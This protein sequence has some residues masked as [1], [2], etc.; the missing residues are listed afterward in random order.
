V[1]L[2]YKVNL[3]KSHFKCE[4]ENI[5]EPK[6][7]KVGVMPGLTHSVDLGMRRRMDPAVKG[8]M[9][10]QKARFLTKDV[11]KQ[12][13]KQ[14]V[15]QA[16]MA[17]QNSQKQPLLAGVDESTIDALHVKQITDETNKQEEK[18]KVGKINKVCTK[19]AKKMQTTKKCV[20][21]K[22][23]EN[24]CQVFLFSYNCDQCEFGSMCKQALKTHEIKHVRFS[25]KIGVFRSFIWRTIRKIVAKLV[26]CQHG[27]T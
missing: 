14:K 17:K 24:L 5:I 3:V 7:L 20:K 16:R 21:F 4:S 10:H 25:S 1:R 8:H 18:E 15:L 23:D 27:P 13:L 11:T 9:V 6:E 26:F 19:E 22:A 12:S 2:I